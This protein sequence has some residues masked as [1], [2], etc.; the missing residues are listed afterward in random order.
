MI[1]FMVLTVL[2]IILLDK[3]IMQLIGK[4]I[5]L[6]K[7]APNF[8]SRL[9]TGDIVWKSPNIS[10][11]SRRSIFNCDMIY[12]SKLSE[13]Y[14]ITRYTHGRRLFQLLYGILLKH[15]GPIMM[16]YKLDKDFKLI[17]KM[18]IYNSSDP[19]AGMT[20]TNKLY[21]N[22]EDPRI[23]YNEDLMKFTIQATVYWNDKRK[24]LAHGTLE[25]IEGEEK[26]CWKIKKQCFIKNKEKDSH[27]NWSYITKNL[28]LTHAHPL[29]QIVEMDTTGKSRIILS[30]NNTHPISL[31]CTTKF[32][33]LTED[34]YLTLLHTYSPYRTVFCKVD[35]KTLLPID[36]SEP[37]HFFENFFNDIEFPSGLCIC[38]NQVYIGLGIND[39][40]C[41]IIKLSKEKVL[42]LFRK[43]I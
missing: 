35:K 9:M 17:H 11:F 25:V 5:I 40:K 18:P 38:D 29:W 32:Q 13:W 19:I 33:S 36:Y 2:I 24:T 31:R 20:S 12:D 21:V 27:K 37:V 10:I 22:G 3:V 26:L 14:V 42:S 23:F 30:V 6:F 1:Q 39:L 34:T 43:I 16:M 15:T 7:R 8:T 41:V 4:S 28:Y